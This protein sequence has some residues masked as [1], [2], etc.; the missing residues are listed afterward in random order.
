MTRAVSEKI[1]VHV[2]KGVAGSEGECATELSLK[3]G[4]LVRI[5]ASA[6]YESWPKVPKETKQYLMDLLLVK[7]VFVC[8]R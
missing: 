7:I 5:N 4:S 8:S 2:L 6:W 1:Q 3:I